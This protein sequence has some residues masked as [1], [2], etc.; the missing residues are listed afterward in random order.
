MQKKIE[1][2]V[3]IVVPDNHQ[4]VFNNSI[5]LSLDCFICKRKGRTVL[6]TETPPAAVCIKT[7]HPFPGKLFKFNTQKKEFENSQIIKAVYSSEFEYRDFMD[8]KDQLPSEDILPS[9]GRIGA[10]ITCSSCHTMTEI[11][12]QNNLRRPIEQKCRCGRVLYIDKKPQPHF[13]FI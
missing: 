1:A 10:K 9:W 12:I 2:S 8:E 6:F 4:I 3:E 11:F 13:S 5:E 7:E